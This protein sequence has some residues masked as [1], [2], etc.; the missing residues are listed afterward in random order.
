MFELSSSAIDYLR[1]KDPTSNVVTPW[2]LQAA[3]TLNPELNRLFLGVES[4]VLPVTI[5]FGPQDFLHQLSQ[6]FVAGLMVSYDL[7]VAPAPEIKLFGQLV[8][9]TDLQ[10]KYQIDT[11]A[12]FHRPYSMSTGAGNYEFDDPSFLQGY[13][14]GLLWQNITEETKI[15][16][17][18]HEDQVVTMM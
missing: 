12:E 13:K 9:W 16:E 5:T 3:M 11:D 10:A 17:L 6:D 2:T 4:T 15:S 8:Q 18:R 14:T 7:H 1:R